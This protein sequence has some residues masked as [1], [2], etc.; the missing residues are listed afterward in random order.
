MLRD[1]VQLRR[2]IAACSSLVRNSQVNSPR[3][4]SRGVAA[5]RFFRAVSLGLM[6]SLRVVDQAGNGTDYEVEVVPRI[7]ERVV[8][9]YGVGRRPVSEHY[10]RVQDVMYKLGNK[11]DARTES[12]AAAETTVKSRANQERIVKDKVSACGICVY[13]M[14]SQLSCSTAR[15]D[16]HKLPR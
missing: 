9:V 15:W 6:L 7:G 5:P 12:C 4:V 10:F 16:S 14:D 1:P 13:T 3:R 8:L 2:L 11:P